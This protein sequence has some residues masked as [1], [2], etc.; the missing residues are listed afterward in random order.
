MRGVIYDHT[1]ALPHT[2]ACITATYCC[3]LP[4]ARLPHTAALVLPHTVTHGCRAR[5]LLL[6]HCRMLP[7]TTALLQNPLPHYC[8]LPHDY[9]TARNYRALCRTAAHCRIHCHTLPRA[10]IPHTAVHTAAHSR[11]HCRTLSQ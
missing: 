9:W 4:H 10:L 5:I 8:T 2:A 1:A 7:H 11:G 3:S 6:P